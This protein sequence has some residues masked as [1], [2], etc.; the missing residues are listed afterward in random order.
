MCKCLIGK[1]I[2]SSLQLGVISMIHCQKYSFD[3]LYNVEKCQNNEKCPSNLDRYVVLS[4][5]DHLQTGQKSVG[6]L[7]NEKMNPTFLSFT[8]QL[9]SSKL[10]RRTN[11]PENIFNVD[12]KQSNISISL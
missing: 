12:T 9:T 1:I 2:N 6:L 8:D 4:W 7:P 3:Q 5:S 10:K 11:L